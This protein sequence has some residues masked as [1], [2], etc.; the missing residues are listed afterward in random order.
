MDF[1]VCHRRVGDDFG[2]SFISGKD[3]HFL[4]YPSNSGSL[5]RDVLKHHPVFEFM[6]TGSV[7]CKC[8]RGMVIHNDEVDLCLKH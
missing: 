3:A 8:Y 2:E 5:R 7:P 1:P 4:I 6:Q